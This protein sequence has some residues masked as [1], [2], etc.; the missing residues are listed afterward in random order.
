MRL[1]SSKPLR[2]ALIC[3]ALCALTSSRSVATVP[4]VLTHTTQVKALSNPDAAQKIPVNLEATVTYVRPSEK[5]LFVIEDGAGIY[6]RFGQDIGLQP[7][8]RIAI[9][10]F[11]EP[12]FRPIVVARQ[13]RFLKHGALPNPQ[14]ARFQDLIRSRWDSQ[15]V[16]ITGHVLSAALDDSGPTPSLRIR[17][18]IPDGTAEGIVAHPGHLAPQELLDTDVRLTGVAGGEFDSKMQMAG[19]W[20]DMNSS[21]DVEFLHRPASSPWLLP[22]VPMDQVIFNFRSNNQSHRVRITGTLTYFEP[23][24]LAVIEHLGLSMLVNTRSALPLHAGSGIEVTG[25]PAIS[26][27]TVHLD[28]GQL[29]PIEEAA[30]MQP[31]NIGWEDASA[32]KYAH[33]LVAMEGEVVGA[34][35]DS[36]VDLFIILTQGHLFAATMRHSSSDASVKVETYRTPA[37]GSRVRITGVCFVDAGNHWR[38]RM[39]FDLRMRSLNDIV[40]LHEPSWWTVKRL[41]YI[42]TMLSLVIVVA[43]LWVWQ[44]DRRLRAQSAILTRQG[45]E[46]AARE[47]VLA[48]LEQQRSHILELISSSESLPEVL[49][50]IRSMVSSRLHGTPVWCE[51]NPLAGGTSA[52]ERP[53]N[54]SA[55]FEELFSPEGQSL[56]FLVATPS[57][58]DSLM[59]L[60]A[61]MVA[62]ARLAELAIDTSRLYSD[63]R[64]RS[65]YDLLTDIPNRFC[66]EKHLTQLLLSAGRSGEAFGL[67]YVDLDKFKAVN[68]RYGHR[69]GDL[70]LQQVTQRMKAQLRIGDMLARIG[71][72]EFIALT[73]ALR[74]RADAEEIALRLERCFDDPF[75]I[76]GY[77]LTGSASVGL[78]VYPEDGSNQEELQRAADTAMYAHKDAK[79]EQDKLTDMMQQVGGFKN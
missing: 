56:G 66:M 12:S 18:K 47:R 57:A 2:G 16:R 45:Q 43:V 36:R 24:S 34:V 61:A 50:E 30:P 62:G 38:D 54:P 28:D 77:R 51:L 6:V 7:G 15:Y 25:F 14:P 20:L 5:N 22:A 27:E 8:D 79:R 55:V 21:R 19:I 48:R 11:T 74:S 42:V 49:R 60:S 78:A 1:I 33:N 59:D 53:S 17:V 35:H 63:L 52:A 39:W 75:E 58:S 73:P 72:D 64:H 44:L 37:I 3:A 68:D 76:D 29:R 10:G 32:G 9:S 65:E 41:A 69:T 23:G 71:G 31:R 26:E 4:A 70:Y 13:I 40:V 46:E 67:I